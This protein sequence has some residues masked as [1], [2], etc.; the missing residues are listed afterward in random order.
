MNTK[1]KTLCESLTQQFDSIPEK[2]KEI[3]AKISSLRKLASN[4]SALSRVQFRLGLPTTVIR[5]LGPSISNNVESKL[6]HV[7][8]ELVEG[9][10][11]FLYKWLSAGEL[12]AACPLLTW[13]QT[14]EVEGGLME[15]FPGEEGKGK[16]EGK[17]QR[18]CT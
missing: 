9:M 10:T 14:S 13:Y 2:R 5:V 18:L 4:Q 16:R 12:D 7:N 8:F 3:L 1:I 6:S 17:V 11:G 15:R